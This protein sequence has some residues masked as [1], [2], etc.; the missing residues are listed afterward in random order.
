M[1][2]HVVWALLAKAKVFG[3]RALKE[4]GSL[5]SPDT[6][7]AWHRRLI[8]RKDT[9]HQRRGL[10]HPRVRAEI[11]NGSCEWRGRIV[12]GATHASAAG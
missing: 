11:R 5:V 12:S 4:C 2:I 10:G 3:R 6:L 1:S 8:V 7:L 9:G